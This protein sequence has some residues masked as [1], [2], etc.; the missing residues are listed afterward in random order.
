MQFTLFSLLLTFIALT[1]HYLK[2]THSSTCTST[3]T[4][5][6]FGT[7]KTVKTLQAKKNITI[8]SPRDLGFNTVDN[9]VYIDYNS[10]RNQNKYE[11]DLNIVQ[12]NVRG[13]KSKLDDLS[14]LLVDMKLPDVMIISETWLKA[15]EEKFINI[16]GYNFIGAPRPNK[17]GGGIGF[18][19][20]NGLLYREL[21]ELNQLN[22]SNT[23]ERYYI[24]LKGD[25]QNVVLGSIYR[26]PNTC[27]ET[28]LS[29]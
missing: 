25:H 23:F 5:M 12:L 21:T 17:K 15:G 14:T 3:S 24:E 20:K 19:V 16:E 11:G 10:I 22:I 13:L 2:R 1:T 7:V 29:E 26:P 27:L 28:F 9:C 6:C 18:L 4:I 8:N